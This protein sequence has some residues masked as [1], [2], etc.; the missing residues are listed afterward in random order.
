MRSCILRVCEQ[1]GTARLGLDGD[2][3]SDL[4]SM[5]L[6][7]TMRIVALAGLLLW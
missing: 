4:G 5:P 3:E 1:M 7:C 2:V 6:R